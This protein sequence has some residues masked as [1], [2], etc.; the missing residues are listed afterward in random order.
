MEAR[1]ELSHAMREAREDWGR[2]T[3][4]ILIVLATLTMVVSLVR[5]EQLPVISNGLLLAGVFTVGSAISRR[6]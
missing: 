6:G 4:I 3:S 5:A 2:S 1:N